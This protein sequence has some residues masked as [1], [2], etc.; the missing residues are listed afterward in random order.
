MTETDVFIISASRAPQLEPAIRDSIK[1]LGA[2]LNRVQDAIFGWDDQPPANTGEI[3]GLTGLACPGINIPSSMRALF[4]AAQ[5]ILAGDVDVVLVCGQGG[6][7]CFGLLLAS[8]A[9]VGRFNLS[10]L[11]EDFLLQ[12][13]RGPARGKPDA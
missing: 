3:L 10:P 9:A 12:H 11:D 7:G 4:F 8:P 6:A 2:N 5:S 1:P 13:F